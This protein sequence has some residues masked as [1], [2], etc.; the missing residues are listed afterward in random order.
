MKFRQNEDEYNNEYNYAEWFPESEISNSLYG[1]NVIQDAENGVFF[2][3]LFNFITEIS[4][5][6]F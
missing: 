5:N 4:M 2:E 3:E 6:F 1:T